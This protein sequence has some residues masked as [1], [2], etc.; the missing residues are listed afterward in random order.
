MRTELYDVWRVLFLHFC[1][2]TVVFASASC[3]MEN[4]GRPVQEGRITVSSQDETA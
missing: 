4:S 1:S 3:G 2:G